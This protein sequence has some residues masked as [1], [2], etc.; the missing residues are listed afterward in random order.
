MTPSLYLVH[1][2]VAHPYFIGGRVVYIHPHR[3]YKYLKPVAHWATGAGLFI[4]AVGVY[5]QL[6]PL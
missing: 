3:Y 5:I 2:W 1:G 4:L 6:C